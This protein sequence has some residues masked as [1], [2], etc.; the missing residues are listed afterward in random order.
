MSAV[1]K[2]C[3][4]TGT[5][6]EGRKALRQ[7]IIRVL[8]TGAIGLALVAAAGCNSTSTTSNGGSGKC[9]FE[10]GFFGALTGSAA[11]L[12]VNIEQ[13]VALAVQ[14]YNAKNGANCITVKKFDSQGSPDKAPSLARQAATDKKLLAMVG[15]AFS[16]ESLVA[17]PI[18]NSAGIPIVTPSATNPTL[19]TKGWKYFHR[20]LAND[21]SQGP[22]DALFIKNVLKAKKV[23]VVDD[24]SAYGAGLAGVVKST[25]G[26]AVVGTD[27][28]AADGQQSDFS[29]TVTKVKSSGADALFYGGYY[30]NAGL[31]RKQLTQAGW[32]GTLVAG[33]GVK[34]PGYVKTAGAAAAN[35]SYLTVPGTPPTN[36]K[37]TFVADYKKKFNVDPGTYS[38]TA[39]DLTNFVLQGLSKG[40]STRDKINNYLNTTAYTGVSNTYKFTSTGELDKQYL[41]VW[42]Y[43]V[44]NGDIVPDQEAPLS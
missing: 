9:G 12:G 10:I 26:S 44:S 17:D 6:K 18:L 32:K 24:Q 43:K 19:S 27:K 4:R 23:F 11:N 5:S 25:L 13:G 20:G 41:K 36:A 39:F 22:A 15:P 33:D 7:G 28:V 14:Q 40:N 37:G 8:G 16:A 34:D 38:D 3:S 35:G 42:V 21:D 31:I 2:M 30:T 29:A 1:A